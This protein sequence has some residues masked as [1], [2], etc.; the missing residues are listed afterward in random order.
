MSASARVALLFGAVLYGHFAMAQHVD[1]APLSPEVIDRVKADIR[2]GRSNLASNVIDR[3]LAEASILVAREEARTGAPLSQRLMLFTSKASELDSARSETIARIDAARAELLAA[4]AAVKAKGLEDLRGAIAARFDRLQSLLVAAG[5]APDEVEFSLRVQRLKEMLASLQRPTSGTALRSDVVPTL[6]QAAP[7]PSAPARK[8]SL[9]P[10]YTEYQIEP[11]RYAYN[12]RE[13]LAAL[14]PP[15]ASADCDHVAADLDKNT[16]DAKVT[17]EIAALAQKLEYSPVKILDYVVNEIRFEPYWGSLKG[18]QGTLHSKAGGPTDHASLLIALLRESNIP[19]RYVRGTIEFYDQRG[20]DWIGTK[21]HKAAAAALA[22]G[23][24]PHATWVSDPG[25]PSQEIGTRFAHVWV[26]ACVPYSNYRGTRTDRSGYRWIPLDPSFKEYSYQPGIAHSAVF[27]FQQ[28]LSRRSSDLP[29]EVYSRNVEAAIKALPPRH[30]NN[31]LADVPYAGKRKARRFDILPSTLPYR[32]FSFDAWDDGLGTEVAQL[33]DRHRYK[34]S[35]VP[36]NASGS[37]LL[38]TSVELRLPEVLL[39]RITLAWKGATVDDQAALDAWMAQGLS[40]GAPCSVN[41]IPEL[42]ADGSALASGST[43]VGLCTENNQLT[44]QVLLDDPSYIV[45]PAVLNEVSYSNIRA[46]DIHALIAYALQASD[47]LISERAARLLDS[48]RGNIGQGLGPNADPDGILGEFLHIN[49]LK[50]VRYFSDAVRLVGTLDSA[51]GGSRN[52]LGLTSS[53]AKVEYLFDLP[54]AVYRSGYLIDMP[55]AVVAS[56]DISTGEAQAWQSY[57]VMGYA[58]SAYESYIWQENAKLDAVS[59]ARG[60][61]FARETGIEVLTLT[62]S[63]WAAESPKLTSNANPERNYSSADVSTLQGSYID[64]G[65]TLTIPRSLIQYGNWKGKVFA[66]ENS[67]A[68]LASFAIGQHAGGYTVDDLL[69][70]YNYSQDFNFGYAYGGVTEE[71]SLLNFEI[72]TIL[73]SLVGF[74]FTSGATFTGDPVNAVNGNVYHVERDISIKGRGGLPIV[75]ERSY[76]SRLPK[77]GPLGFG[78]THSF[79]HFLT[80]KD[81]NLGGTSNGASNDG[82]TSS[83]VWTDGTGSEKYIRIAGAGAGGVS[84]S[85]IFSSPSGFHFQAAR[86]TDGTY[87]VREKN[88]L[89]YSFEVAAGTIGQKARLARISD[90]G[91]NALVLTY[92]GANLAAVAD[93]LGRNLTFTSDPSGRIVEVADWSG[94]RFQYGFDAQGNLTSFKNPLAVA[95]NQEPVTYEYYADSSIDSQGNPAPLNHA[96][97]RYTLPRGNSMT[98]EYYMNGRAFRHYN[99]LEE[100]TTFSYN[101]FRRET[102]QINERG[103]TRRFF[104]DANGN[105]LKIVAEDGAERSYTYDCAQPGDPANCANP[106]NRLSKRGP[107]GYATQYAYDANGNVTRI[108]NPSGATIEFSHF[109]LFGQPGKVKDVRGNYSVLK[110]DANGNVLQEIRLKSGVGAGVDP[111]TYAPGASDVVGWTIHTYDAYS[112]RLT[113]KRV[114]DFS[115]QAGPTITYTYDDSDLNPVTVTRAGV[116][117][118]GQAGNENA[119]FSHDSLGRARS[120]PRPDWYPFQADYDDVD[121]VVR[122]TAPTGEPKATL[123]DPNGNVLGDQLFSGANVVDTTSFSYDLSD[124]LIQSTDSAGYATKLVRDAAGNMIRATNPD[125]YAVTFDYDEAN[126]A[127]LA[128]NEKGNA[129]QRVFDLDGKPRAVI[130]PNGNAVSYEYYGPE[131]DGRLRRIAWPAIQTFLSGRAVEYDYDAAGNRVSTC[132]IPASTTDPSP[133]CSGAARLELS[134]YD[135]LNRLVRSAGPAFVDQVPDSSTF[136]Q[137]IRP[138]LR[139]GYDALGNLVEMSAGR[140]DASGT[141]PAADVVTVQATYTYDDFGR[142]LSRTDALNRTWSWQYDSQGNVTKSVDARGQAL[143]FVYFPGHGR[144]LKCATKDVPPS[145]W[146]AFDADC[147]SGANV[148]ARYERDAR[149]LI[150]LAQSPEVTYTYTY[151]AAKRVA[152]VTDSRG[153]KTLTY[154]WS[155]GGRLNR[156]VDAEGKATDYLYDSVGRLAGIWAPGGD[157]VRFE[158]DAGGR[159]VQKWLNAQVGTEYGYDRDNSLLIATN[160]LPGGYFSRHQYGYDGFGARLTRRD[161]NGQYDFRWRFEYDG[162]GRLAAQHLSHNVGQGGQPVAQQPEALY[163]SYAYDAPGNLRREVYADGTLEVQVVDAANQLKER[164]FYVGGNLV[165]LQAWG[166]DDNG[167][168]TSRDFGEGDVATYGYD[169]QNRLVSATRPGQYEQ[170]YGYDHQG[171]RVRKSVSGTPTHFLYDGED[172]YAEYAAWASPLARTTYGPRWDEP[173][174]RDTGVAAEKRFYHADGQGSVV[175]LTDAQGGLAWG[176]FYEAWGTDAFGPLG[177]ASPPQRYTGREAD[178][179]SLYYYRARYYFAFARRFVQPDPIG[180]AGGS[181]NLYAYVGNDPVNFT[182]PTGECPWCVTGLIGGSGAALA[183]KLSGASWT[184]TGLAFVGGF[185]VGSGLAFI[186]APALVATGITATTRLSA[187]VAATIGTVTV[188]SASSAG[189]DALVQSGSMLFDLARG[190][191]P[192]DYNLGRTGLAAF[193]GAAG[194]GPAAAAAY[195]RTV[196]AELYGAGSLAALAHQVTVGQQIAFAGVEV[197]TSVVTN[198]TSNFISDSL[199]NIA[200]GDAGTLDWSFTDGASNLGT[201]SSGSPVAP[202]AGSVTTGFNPRGSK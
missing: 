197:L 137:T 4:G 35:I 150:T 73:N 28:F 50:F 176:A 19:A 196:A 2:L 104:F 170:S 20:P 71:H 149:G 108:T 184:E 172:L 127:R 119:S 135:E 6:R 151:D 116:L 62:A 29:H 23:A 152:T 190:N 134:S 88:G 66:A 111:A 43:S 80:F 201:F 98:F 174:I 56:R 198:E 199:W 126:R 139:Y 12:G 34:F 178:E 147:G 33:P 26:E 193:A 97:K 47:R 1:I 145:G 53:Q 31:T 87:T 175:A 143:Y 61:Q 113:T 101:D 114:K 27:D 132:S 188:G 158:F 76:N 18:A 5:R 72:P 165:D 25:N 89:T 65:Y 46:A 69:N 90:R 81:D 146:P 141:N 129:V 117:G 45:H 78:W 39:K 160:F 164:R 48:V 138:V 128:Y 7:V 58:G 136:G 44:M 195:G 153:P 30:A 67:A 155:N 107:M 99:T 77:A 179:T 173:L 192:Q 49:A 38:T 32:V 60:I 91:G 14:D 86:Q 185:A 120:G 121:R 156:L 140:T 105:P 24:Y 142:R 36:K 79:N 40:E 130:D 159:L 3:H 15:P 181:V 21:T 123:F 133:S 22:L 189:T 169:A 37:P 94:R 103:H 115:T 84:A 180:Y 85:S 54:F 182:D 68:G 168:L 131:R 92:N 96:M 10:K 118:E 125:D 124:R 42:R 93:G 75:F 82:I 100:T 57:M 194:S 177:E 166:Y 63:N 16:L 51:T 171:R 162:L 154:T 59:T 167:N 163:G 52:H 83:M 70:L 13:L 183:A 55:G 200:A 122:V 110:Y 186:G 9:R 112:N 64:Q 8:S 106:F 187:P 148:L 74:G 11:I 41:V 17:F 95:G 202:Y 144:Q 157:Y 102:V 161:E 191:N 109:D